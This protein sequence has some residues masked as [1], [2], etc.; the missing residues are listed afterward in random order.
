MKNVFVTVITR[1]VNMS[2][3]GMSY[4]FPHNFVTCRKAHYFFFPSSLLTRLLINALCAAFTLV[5]TPSI[6]VRNDF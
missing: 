6:L 5:L 1:Q 2:R 4:D 3:V